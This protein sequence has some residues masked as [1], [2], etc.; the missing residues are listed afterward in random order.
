[1]VT[2]TE[3]AELQTDLTGIRQRVAELKGQATLLRDQQEKQQTLETEG[4]ARTELLAKTLVV[5]QQLEET[6]RGKYEE[7]L[8]AL[9]SQGLN[10]VFIDDEY[11]L[12]LESTIRR[13]VAN[14]DIVLVKNGERVRLKGGTGG[15]VVQVLS[16]LL[17]HL[18]TTSQQPEWRRLEV[19]DEPFSML[20]VEQR[21]ALCELI[22]EITKRLDFQLVFSSHEGELAEAA[23]VVYEVRP[24]GKVQ[25]IKFQGED[26]A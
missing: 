26:R 14:L 8:A 11:E 12:L 21:P 7:A 19:L 1:M 3:L 9:G 25:Q 5:L 15:S 22:K 4:L 24:G 17:R 18:M 23:D 20:A 13:G 10:A 6:W 16:Y 2:L